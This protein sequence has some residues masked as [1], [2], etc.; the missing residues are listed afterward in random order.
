MLSPIL[1]VRLGTSGTCGRQK[2]EFGYS[3]FVGPVIWKGGTTGCDMLG[4]A[5]SPGP[6]M[7]MLMYIIAVLWPGQMST[8]GLSRICWFSYLET[9]QVEWQQHLPRLATDFCS[10]SS[11]CPHMDTSTAGYK[12]EEISGSPEHG[13]C[14][15]S[16]EQTPSYS[17]VGKCVL[18]VHIVFTQG[19]NIILR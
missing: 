5:T 16:A 6:L 12:T 4:G 15:M 19:M 1:N 7:P 2:D 18:P 13:R 11:A 10:C 3:V 8:V 14:A 9:I 17:P